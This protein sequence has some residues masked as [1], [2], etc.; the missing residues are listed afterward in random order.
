[1]NNNNRSF[2]AFFFGLLLL[3]SLLLLF[4][5]PFI[6]CTGDSYNYSLDVSLDNSVTKN[7]S[8]LR[9]ADEVIRIQQEYSR[10]WASALEKCEKMA[11]SAGLKGK[12]ATNAIDS[13][14]ENF[15]S[16]MPKSK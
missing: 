16:G 10:L 11:S 7:G 12:V 4:T 13:C 9:K 1:M 6:L 5:D 15:I 14:V 8:D 3:I 2:L